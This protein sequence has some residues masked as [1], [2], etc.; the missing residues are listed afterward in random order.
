MQLPT[1]TASAV[2]ILLLSLTDSV[3]ALPKP[4]LSSVSD[5]LSPLFENPSSPPSPPPRSSSNSGSNTYLQDY[6]SNTDNYPTTNDIQGARPFSN[7]HEVEIELRTAQNSYFTERLALNERG[8]GSLKLDA[9]VAQVHHNHDGNRITGARITRSP[10][11]FPTLECFLRADA[12]ERDRSL[13]ALWG[14]ASSSG[15]AAGGGYGGDDYGT[16]D[17]EYYNRG[18]GSRERVYRPESEVYRGRESPYNNNYNNNNNDDDDDDSEVR[19]YFEQSG[20]VEK[21]ALTY[22]YPPIPFELEPSTYYIGSTIHCIS[23]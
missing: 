17:Y 9:N 22:R 23:R 20:Q 5:N 4:Q 18:D 19:E 15:N 11:N 12:L 21:L 8:Y 6:H 1:S 14:D 7:T 3:S 10:I 16:G 13:L 2:S